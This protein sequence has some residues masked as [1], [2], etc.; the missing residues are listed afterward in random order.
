MRDSQNSR[1]KSPRWTTAFADIQNKLSQNATEAVS[2]NVATIND[3]S[4]AIGTMK[5]AYHG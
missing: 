4:S 1:Q 2:Q 3:F 5:A